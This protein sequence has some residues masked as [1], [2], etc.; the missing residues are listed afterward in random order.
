MAFKMQVK[1]LFLDLGRVTQVCS[2]RENP[3]SLMFT[4]FYMYMSIKEIKMLPIWK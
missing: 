2:V 3:S 1:V 4:S